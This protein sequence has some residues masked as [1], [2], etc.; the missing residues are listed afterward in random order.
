MSP[1]FETERDARERLFAEYAALRKLMTS[2]LAATRAALRDERQRPVLRAAVEKLR[3]EVIRYLEL[4]ESIALPML[5]RGSEHG[6]SRAE[7][8]VADHAVDRA[9][10]T[11]LAKN[12]NDPTRPIAALADEIAKFVRAFDQHMTEEH[13]LLEGEWLEPRTGSGLRRAGHP[14]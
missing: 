5:E 13:E 14:Q 12:A 1:S 2:L 9:K 6:R 4:E 8:M 7:K 11:A 3:D 10:L